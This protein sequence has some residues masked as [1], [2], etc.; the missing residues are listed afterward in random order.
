MKNYFEVNWV[1]KDTQWDILYVGYFATYINNTKRTNYAISSARAIVLIENGA[2][3]W[4]V[5]NTWKQKIWVVNSWG[6]KYLRSY[7]DSQWT[8]NLD[9]L[10]SLPVVS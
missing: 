2:E 8:N 7:K 1:T 10:P 9:N 5:D 6:K 4:V 3:F